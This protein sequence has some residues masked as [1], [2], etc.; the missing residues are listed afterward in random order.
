MNLVNSTFII[1]QI[2]SEALQEHS[3]QKTQ[4]IQI[5]SPTLPQAVSTE[6]GPAAFAP[7]HGVACTWTTTTTPYGLKWANLRARECVPNVCT[8][9]GGQP[10]IG[11]DCP[12]HEASACRYSSGTAF[13]GDGIGGPSALLRT[14]PV[15]KTT[16]QMHILLKC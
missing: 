6:L 14:R 15:F 1:H 9:H 12:H 5:T 2:H 16:S 3:I 4:N 10:A 11:T 8:C 7:P 13:P